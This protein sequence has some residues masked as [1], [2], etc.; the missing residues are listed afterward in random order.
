M[1]GDGGGS[2]LTVPVRLRD[3]LVD[4]PPHC[5]WS[6]CGS[7][8]AAATQWLNSLEGSID[9]WTEEF[10]ERLQELLEELHFL[11]HRVSELEK[12]TSAGERRGCKTSSSDG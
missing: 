11:T 10:S 1:D 6:L 2:R 3:D 4:G 9:F 7:K 12:T 5:G 8:H